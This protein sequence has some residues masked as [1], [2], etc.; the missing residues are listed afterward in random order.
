MT[1]SVDQMKADGMHRRTWML[2]IAMAGVLVVAYGC[3]GGSNPMSEPCLQF[4]AA[5]A[6]SA[7]KVV[8]RQASGSTCA[9][10]GI[11][12]V[13]TDVSDVYAASFTLVY[14]ATVMKYIGFLA[15][16]SALADGGVR[17]DVIPDDQP[18]RLT[19][20]ITRV[21]S[22]SGVNVTGTGVL[23]RLDFEKVGT[24][25]SGNVIFENAQLLGSE[26]PPQAKAGIQWA[27]GNA[28]VK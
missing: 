6:P 17:V 11:E 20:G 4:T 2:L 10:V 13:M 5:E 19:I 18:G 27:G 8:A 7:G 24:D 12:C 1:G 22:T 9:A 26:T 21:G 3:D 16:D 23:L 25:G 28:S 15:T 14:P